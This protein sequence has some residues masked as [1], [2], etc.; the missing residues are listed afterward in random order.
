MAEEQYSRGILAAEEQA[1]Q[2]LE[3]FEYIQGNMRTEKLEEFQARLQEA[4]SELL[5]TF[6]GALAQ[7]DPPDSLTRFHDIFVAAV[8]HCRNAREAFLTAGAQDFSLA[9]IDSRRSLC[10]AMNLFYQVRSHLPVLQRYW[11]LPEALPG[12][13]ALEAR[14]PDADVPVGMIH[15]KRPDPLADYSLYVPE[16]YTPSR[17]WPLIISLHGAYGRGDHYIWS[18]LRPAKSKGYMVLSPKS[19]DVTWSV[20]RPPLDVGSITGMF[21]EVC[22]AYAVDRSRVYLSGLSDGGTFTYLL[23]LTRPDMFAG[24]APVA[25]DFHAMLDGMLRQ[26]QGKDL[27]IYI[28]HGVHDAIFSVQSIRSGYGLLTRLGYNATY[29]ELPDW[30]HSYSSKINEELVMPWF[31]SLAAKAG[32]ID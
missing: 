9:S 27:P 30:G 24:I 10:R 6:P 31:E 11:L 4:G 26:K 19:V 13:D 16:N 2:F 23:G 3:T 25:G 18:W 12:R 22:A 17:D 28:V 29:E 15:N 14:S 8:R 5:S 21:D 20:L 1:L 32:A 7:L